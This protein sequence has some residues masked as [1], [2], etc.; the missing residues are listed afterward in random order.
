[1]QWPAALQLL[2]HGA[3]RNM[4]HAC[5]DSSCPQALDN[6]VKVKCRKRALMGVTSDAV[7][8]VPQHGI[9]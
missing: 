1:M 2:Q 8:I 6:L 7:S 3:A 9:C 5:A 4:A